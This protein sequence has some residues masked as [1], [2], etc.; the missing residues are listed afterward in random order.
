MT[1]KTAFFEA[2]SWFKFSN[3]G[4]AV[5]TNLKLY[6]LSKGLKL[7]VRKFWSLI[8]KFVEV[9]EEK[10]VGG[11]FWLRPTPPPP[12]LNRV[13]QLNNR[14]HSLHKKALRITYQDRNSS[15]SELLNIDKSVSFHYGNI[16]YLLTEIYRIK[17]GLC[18]PIM[19]VSS[20]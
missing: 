9:T 19:S 15:F 4:L 14:I 5:G 8:S 2:W 6:S 13:K 1:R 7:K 18:F 11:P 20:V 3:L 16:K 10:L 17:I 12:I